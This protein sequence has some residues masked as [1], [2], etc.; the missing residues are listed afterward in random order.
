MIDFIFTYG[1]EINLIKDHDFIL[2]EKQKETIN[3]PK[4]MGINTFTMGPGDVNGGILGMYT[5][6][7]LIKS[8]FTIFTHYIYI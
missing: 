3:D 2:S 7:Y 6:I 8:K 1:N 4:Y 5:N